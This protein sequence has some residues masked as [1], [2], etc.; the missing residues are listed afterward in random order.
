MASTTRRDTTPATAPSTATPLRARPTCSTPACCWP[1]RW[2]C[3]VSRST[4]SCC[5][6]SSSPSSRPSE[7]TRSSAT[8]PGRRCGCSTTCGSS[9]VGSTSRCRSASSAARCGSSSTT[10]TCPRCRPVSGRTGATTTTAASSPWRTTWPARAHDVT[11]VSKDLPM[12]VKAS[13]MGLAAEEYRGIGRVESG[14]TGMAEVAV[15]G[16]VD[17]C[18]VRR[19]RRADRPGGGSRTALPHRA[20]PGLRARQRTRPGDSRQAGAAGAR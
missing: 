4:R 19:R 17:R 18:A 3:C 1:T 5:R 13:A 9:T 15:A 12:R 14:W 16:D 11:L 8:S 6:S 20:R 10:S 2:R 7:H